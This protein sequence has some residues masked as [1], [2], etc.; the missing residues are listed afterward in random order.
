[1]KI[2]PGVASQA[3]G[4]RIAAELGCELV[5]CE[6]KR[7]PDG[8]SYTRIIGDVEGEHVVVVQSIRSDTDL[9]VLLQLL[10]AAEGA[11]KITAVIPYLGYARQDKRFKPGEAVS[12]RAIARSIC[13]STPALDSIYVVNVHDHAEL[14]YFQVGVDVHVHELDASPPI[15]DYIMKMGIAPASIVVIGPDEG[16][17]EL[18]RAVATPYGFDYDVLEKK[19]LTGDEVEIKPKELGI[20]IEG[21]NIFI[22]DDIISTGGTIAEAT[23]LLREQNAGD[24][25]VACVHG[26]FVQ[27]AVLRMLHAGVKELISTDTVESLFSRVSIAKLVA[28]ELEPK[29]NPGFNDS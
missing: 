11:S 22:V 8:E 15:S 6:F 17:E 4:A 13:F 3:L 16:A 28:K 19:R 24:I 23:K 12:I 9:V 29:L 20:D 27:N 10:D 1:M 25:Y 21:K 2:V 5:S 7:F 14:R 18:A 26:L